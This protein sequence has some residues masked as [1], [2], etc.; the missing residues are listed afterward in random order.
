MNAVIQG[1]SDPDEISER[2]QLDAGEVCSALT[3]L[4]IRGLIK[5]VSMGKYTAETGI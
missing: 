3:L 1:A 2:T 4:E 5:N